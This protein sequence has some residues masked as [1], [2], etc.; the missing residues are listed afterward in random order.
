MVRVA[1]FSLNLRVSLLYTVG[2]KNI[3]EPSMNLFPE[4]SPTF[5][6]VPWPSMGF[7]QIL[8]L[9]QTN[10]KLQKYWEKYARVV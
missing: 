6:H 3:L 5:W 2:V 10:R 7:C 1:Y 4:C 8:R 9:L